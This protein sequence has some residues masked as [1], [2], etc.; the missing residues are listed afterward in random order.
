MAVAYFHDFSGG[1]PEQ[2]QQVNER[3]QVGPEGPPGG[4]YHAEGTTE[5]GYWAFDVWDSEASA[6]RF[7]SER[8]QPVLQDMGVSQPQ[9]RK[10]NVTFESSQPPGQ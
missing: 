10:L 2:A 8:L 9:T 1:T 4:I 7:Y 6:D 5:G 3:L